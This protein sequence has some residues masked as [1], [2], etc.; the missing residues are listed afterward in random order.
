M[1]VNRLVILILCL[2]LVPLVHG[3]PTVRGHGAGTFNASTVNVSWPSGTVASDTAIIYIGNGYAPNLPNGW[4]QIL[5]VGGNWSVLL[6]SRILTAADITTGHV[7]ITTGGSFNGGY[8][9]VTLVGA[10]QF[11]N[12]AYANGNGQPQ[13]VTTDSSPVSGDLG[14][15]FGGYRSSGSTPTANVGS[16]LDSASDSSAAAVSVYDQTISSSGSFSVV[17][18]YTVSW[19]GA[20]VSMVTTAYVLS[21]GGGPI[22]YISGD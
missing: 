17:F 13:T 19:V 21:S 9:V 7:T 14:L 10:C 12:I 18:T 22:G 20:P 11:R 8:T 4:T 5:S 6:L 3:T 2:L 1:S 16:L 15:Y